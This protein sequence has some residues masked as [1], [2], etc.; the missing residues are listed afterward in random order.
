MT[1]EAKLRDSFIAS[2]EN[3]LGYTA[4]ADGT[5]VFG[6]TVGYN[7]KA[8][9]WD[10][11]FID[12]VA[13]EVGLPLPAFVY[14][15][16]ALSN[17]IRNGRLY[18]T[19]KRGDIAFFETSTITDFGPPHVGIVID[20]SRFATD[21]VFTTIEAQVSHGLPRGSALN[22]GVYKRA[23][24]KLD[25]IGF[26]RPNFRINKLITARHSEEQNTSTVL[27]VIV[28]AQVLPNMKHPNV[29]HV[30]LAL[31][32]VTDVRRL[33]RGFFDGKTRSAYAKFQ[34]SIG[35]VPADGVP[36][37]NSL[38]RLAKETGLFTVGQ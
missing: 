26:A 14:T 13:R 31:S 27:P 15:P 4:R 11:A 7:G 23:R 6:E 36:D 3:Y 34:R 37:L 33:P 21:G 5:N 17:Y 38:Q 10:G 8:I 16:Q 19:P 24:S 12:V 9:P 1:A 30:Q 2:A 35:Y 20:A 25:T 22:D 32:V 18:L 28:P 29:Q